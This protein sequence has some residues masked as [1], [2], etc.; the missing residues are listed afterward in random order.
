M[1][2]GTVLDFHRDDWWPEAARRVFLDSEAL[3]AD[4]WIESLLQ[5]EP[6][7]SAVAEL[8]AFIRA[9]R[10]I[11][12]HCTKE[13]APGFYE[14]QGLRILDLNRQQSEFL[15]LHG[16]HFS[17]AEVVDMRCRW[18]DYFGKQQAAA[19]SGKV[20][21]CL[22]H[23]QVVGSGTD[24]LFSLFGGEAVY[25]PLAGVPPLV[26]KLRAIGRPVVIE[27]SLVPDELRVFSPIAFAFNAISLAHRRRKPT[28]PLAGYEGYVSGDIEPSR[29]LRVTPQA[30]FFD[31]YGNLY[32]PY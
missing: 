32:A 4:A 10:V 9:H 12:Y 18:A 26:E 25:M 7:R 22:A 19:R 28:A 3:R 11:G 23:N 6:Y 27:V 8:E 16:H 5:D 24:R 21:F 14:R 13:P 30:E 2:L 1:T 31:T 17:A 20:W 15:E 29:I